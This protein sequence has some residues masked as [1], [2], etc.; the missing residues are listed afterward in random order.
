MSRLNFLIIGSS[1]FI[2]G[3]I[4]KR[5]KKCGHNVITLKRISN[6]SLIKI[7]EKNNIDYCVHAASGIM[8]S[9]SNNDFFEEYSNLIS[10][11]FLLVRFCKQNNIPFIYLS[12]AGA[13]YEDSKSPISEKSSLN[14]STFYGASKYIIEQY[15]LKINLDYLILRPT[16]VYGRDLSNVNINQGFIENSIK[17]IISNKPINLFG[18][19]PKY[20]DFLFVDDLVEIFLMLINNRIMNKT[21]NVGS[22][23]VYELKEIIHQ[24]YR[25]LNKEPNIEITK[26]RDFDKKIIDIDISLLEGLIEYK[27][28]DIYRGLEYYLSDLSI[29]SGNHRR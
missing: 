24:L 15:I 13:V 14:Q 2:G 8:P 25:L 27:S 28:M 1:G 6:S 5:V 23:K 18:S 22:G 9:S 29:L 26:E 21:I 19:S 17:Q 7:K 12:S 4:S 11:T 16:N 3:K 20:R 10:K